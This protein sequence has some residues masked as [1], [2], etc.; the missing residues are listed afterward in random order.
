[1]GLGLGLFGGF[2]QVSFVTWEAL[3]PNRPTTFAVSGGMTVVVGCFHL[4]C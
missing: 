1:M 4:C 3:W 2:C